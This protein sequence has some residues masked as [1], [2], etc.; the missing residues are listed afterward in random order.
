MHYEFDDNKDS[1]NLTKHG[2]S[3]SEADA[4]DWDS[5]VV[6]EDLRKP[7]SERRF[8]AVGYL[9]ERLH[10]MVFCLRADVVRVVSL[11]RA[12]L[13]AVKGYAKT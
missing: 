3:F 6:R 8:Q 5:A 10:V 1:S 12:D 13:R 11:R 2:V 9:N 7:Y 4:F